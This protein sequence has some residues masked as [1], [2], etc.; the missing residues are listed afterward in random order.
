[1]KRDIGASTSSINQTIEI[2]YIVQ[3]FI[4]SL[5]LVTFAKSDICANDISAK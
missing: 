2:W 1:M 3:R 5:S 4:I